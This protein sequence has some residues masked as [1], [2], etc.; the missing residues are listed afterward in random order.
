MDAEEEGMTETRP[1]PFCGHP[2][3]RL[4]H[5]TEY[6]ENAEGLTATVTD[7]DMITGL[8]VSEH[9]VE[10]LDFRHVF[11]RRCNRCGARGGYVRTDWHVRTQ[12]EA[13]YFS[14]FDGQRERLCGFDPDSEWARP[15]REMADEMWNGRHERCDECEGRG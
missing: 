14:P 11:Y 13:D 1:C 3:S 10:M 4:T 2:R 5:R 7:W 6:R 15:W 12:D 9:E 8:D